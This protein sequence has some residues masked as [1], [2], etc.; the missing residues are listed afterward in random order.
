[1]EAA[2]SSL[3]LLCFEKS[4]KNYIPKDSNLL[5][6][7]KMYRVIQDKRGKILGG[8]SIGH[9]EKTKSLYECVTNSEWPPRQSCLNLAV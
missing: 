6:L 1:M 8:D 5:S 9:C 3:M 2:G 7:L 4:R